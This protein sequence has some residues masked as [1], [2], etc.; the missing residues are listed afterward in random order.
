MLRDPPVAQAC[1]NHPGGLL[2]AEVRSPDG[3]LPR[4]YRLRL[5]MCVSFASMKMKLLCRRSRCGRRA[6][7]RSASPAGP[8]RTPPGAARFRHV[9]VDAVG[10]HAVRRQAIDAAVE[11]PAARSVDVLL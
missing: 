3:T 2:R 10:E 5:K 9:V 4:P 7:G 11:G 8:A 1:N 6:P